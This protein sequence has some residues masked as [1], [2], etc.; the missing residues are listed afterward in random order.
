MR[1]GFKNKEIKEQIPNSKYKK[2]NSTRGIGTKNRVQDSRFN[3]QHQKT[4]I[5]YNTL[6]RTKKCFY[7]RQTSKIELKKSKK[8]S[9]EIR[10]KSKNYVKFQSH[11]SGEILYF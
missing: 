6:S 8:N 5:S 10:I 11:Y 2:T 9:Q 1:F 4:Q 3:I 7:F